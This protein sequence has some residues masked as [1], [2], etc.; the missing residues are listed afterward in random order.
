VLTGDLIKSSRFS[1]K[2]RRQT[3][4]AIEDLA[5]H[6]P[7]L[8]G[9]TV[10][11]PEIFRGD[12][13]QLL[14]SESRYALHAACCIRAGLR[15]RNLLD[16]R[17]GIGIG[18]AQVSPDRLG[19]S[20]GIAFRLSGAALDELM[21]GETLACRVDAL[22]GNNPVQSLLDAA[23]GFAAR[24]MDE[25][26]LLQAFAVEKALAGLTQKKIA[27]EW[28]NGATTQQNVTAM[29]RRAGWPQLSRLFTAFQ[30]A[31]NN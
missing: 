23:L 12:S 2:Q 19:Q 3:I 15:S 1:M 10:I 9:G 18:D 16:T 17:I 24:V 21:R 22:A 31:I 25:W 30:H 7:A 4:S 8:F 14:L 13:W 29:L 6:M 26:S 11:G 20:D 28:P 5:A 27:A